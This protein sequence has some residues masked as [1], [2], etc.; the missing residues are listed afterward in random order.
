MIDE[1]HR[2]TGNYAYCEVI[3]L[4]IL[5]DAVFRVLALSAT[6][7]SDTKSVQAVV[8]NILI[9]KVEIRT[10]ESM[11]IQPFIFK[12]SIQEIILDPSPLMNEIAAMFFNVV[13]PYFK[14]LTQN[15]AINTPDPRNVG[16]YALMMARD[17]WRPF[18]KN[19]NPALSGMIEGDFGI[20]IALCRTFTLLSSHG[21]NVFH[22]SLLAYINEAKDVTKKVSVSRTKLLKDVSLNQLLQFIP[23]RISSPGF[24]THPKMENLVGLVIK[25]FTD[26]QTDMDIGLI[27]DDSE[28]KI[29]IFTQFRD[30]VDE[31]LSILNDH[32]PLIR[33]MSFVGQAAKK[34]S[35]KGF[36][37]K[38]QLKVI[39]DFQKGVFNVLVATSIGEEGLD[40]GEIDLILCFDS[41]GSPI[42]MLQRMGRTGRKRKGKIVLLMCKGNMII[43]S[44]QRRGILSSGASKI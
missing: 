15:K 40:I 31:I 18:S 29:M 5:K 21:I 4:M 37:Q 32:K 25:H 19:L 34:G 14:R 43:Y 10:E 23:Q 24:V 26:H 12:R 3:K 2:A 42:R 22:N 1:A 30:S 6:P 38:E 27:D 8:D 20:A 44:R 9:Q 7:G 33:P 17:R 35:G 13:E 41:Q 11:D 39:S 36:T 28:T 16:H